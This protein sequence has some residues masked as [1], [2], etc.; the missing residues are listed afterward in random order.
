MSVLDMPQ[1]S[2]A[3]PMR[4]R[5]GTQPS[6]I[7]PLGLTL[8]G[9][10]SGTV[11]LAQEAAPQAS[12]WESTSAGIPVG[13]I[14]S[15]GHAIAELRRITGLT[16]DQL[17]RLFGVSRR[18]IH[19][20]ASGKMMNSTNEERLARILAVWRGMDRGSVQANRAAIVAIHADGSC[21]FELLAAGDYERAASVGSGGESGRMSWPKP[22]TTTLATRAPRAPE[23]LVD[24]L[25]DGVPR[26]RGRVLGTT[27]V[28]VTRRK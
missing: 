24:A 1:T 21:I 11:G 25:E 15:A 22:S 7:L 27:P 9:T 18:A 23:M 10:S 8:P 5:A 16:W 13:P 6:Y 4:K 19:F 3:G 12:A 28:K 26:G 20:W 17:A 2:A 14:E